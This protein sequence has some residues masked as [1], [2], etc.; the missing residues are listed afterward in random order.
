MQVGG[1]QSQQAREDQQGVE[2]PVRTCHDDETGSAPLENPV[3]PT[4]LLATVYHA[5]GL[6]PRRTILNHLNQP[7][8]M[9][10]GDAITA[11]LA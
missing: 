8:E 6:N 3:H 7:R 5:F 2:Y 4:D 10:N 1:Q 9:V 11:V